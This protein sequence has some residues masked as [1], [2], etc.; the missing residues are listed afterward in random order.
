MLLVS[1][2]DGPPVQFAVNGVLDH[3]FPIVTGGLAVQQKL[4]APR[5]FVASA[6]P[7]VVGQGAIARPV[8]ITGTDFVDG[9]GFGVDFG[10]GT[11]PIVGLVTTT[12]VDLTLDVDPGA[13]PGMR[14]IAVT[15]DAGGTGFILGFE[16][17]PFTTTGT[18]PTN[19]TQVVQG[20]T[21]TLGIFTDGF[22]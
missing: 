9:A 12:S 7:G 8:T 4:D 14:V 16:V 13:V 6:T 5:P 21:A 3:V 17:E 20:G 1:P 22:E 19:P 18:S 11:T 15:N 2:V 10:P